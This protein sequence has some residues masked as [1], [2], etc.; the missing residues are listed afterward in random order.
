MDWS[1]VSGAVVVL[2]CL[3]VLF[4]L[5]LAYVARRFHVHEDPRIGEVHDL[6]PKVDC[7]ACG[8]AGCRAYAEA[9]VKGEVGPS[10]CVPGG[11]G[12]AKAVADYLGV[13]AEE[14]ERVVAVLRCNGRRVADRF[15]M[16]GLEDCKAAV[17]L[18]GG[19][20]ACPYGCVGLGNCARVCPVNAIV[21]EEGFPRVIAERCIGCGACVKECPKGLFVLRPESK[22]VHVL[23]S[24]QAKGA[25]VKKV[26]AVGCIGCKKCEKVCPVDAVKVENFLASI[27]PEKCINCGKCVKE[28]PTNAIRDFRKPPRPEDQAARSTAAAI[29]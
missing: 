11:A 16:V 7:G 1:L 25:Q 12:T 3:G 17:L 29:A 5:L 2:A 23:C 10:E 22:K 27:D 18:H 26:C 6:L 20:K 21:M 9:V 14:K 4:G 8:F 15:E 13:E 24:S 19:P 28:C